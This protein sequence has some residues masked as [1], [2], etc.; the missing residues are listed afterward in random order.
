MPISGNDRKNA[1]RGIWRA[2]SDLKKYNRIR[3]GTKGSW[4]LAD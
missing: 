2:I 3:Q 4:M 1:T